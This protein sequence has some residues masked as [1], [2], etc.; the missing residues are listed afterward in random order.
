MGGRHRHGKYRRR[1]MYVGVGHAVD[2]T[3]KGG[4]TR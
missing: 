1:F 3:S 2:G 4:G